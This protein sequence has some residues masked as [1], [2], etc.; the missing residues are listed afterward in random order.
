M[1]P[2][3]FAGFGHQSD[4]QVLERRLVGGSEAQWSVGNARRC[5]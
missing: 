5:W 3:R 4:Q 1:R 2:D